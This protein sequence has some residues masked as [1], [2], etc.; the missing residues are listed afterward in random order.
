[1]RATRSSPNFPYTGD[2]SSYQQASEQVKLLER[3]HPAPRDVRAKGGVS[4]QDLDQ[5]ETQLNIAKM[6]LEAARRATSSRPRPR[7]RHRRP[8][9]GRQKFRAWAR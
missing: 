7:C 2:N 5:S 9:Q 6:Q 3:R 8:F 1:M 4:Q